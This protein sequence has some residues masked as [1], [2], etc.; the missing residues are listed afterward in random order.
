MRRF[1]YLYNGNELSQEIEEDPSGTMVIPGIGSV[2]TRQGRE[3]KVVR[4]VAP[5]SAG[6]TT[7]IVRVFLNDPVRIKGR[8]LGVKHLP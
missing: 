4:V 1:I 3:W 8:T 6:G 2:V 5:V 7:P